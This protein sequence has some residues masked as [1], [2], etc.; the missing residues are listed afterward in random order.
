[1]ANLHSLSVPLISC[2]SSASITSER[3]KEISPHPAM[4]SRFGMDELDSVSTVRRALRW[5]LDVYGLSDNLILFEKDQHQRYRS[6][7]Q[8]RRLSQSLPLPKCHLCPPQESE[9]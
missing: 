2:A 1:M 8:F 3:T 5:C 9:L 4:R 6:G 7:P